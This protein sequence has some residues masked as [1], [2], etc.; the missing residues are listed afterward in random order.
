M[1]MVTITVESTRV[2]W[3]SY[4]EGALSMEAQHTP[5]TSTS[6]LT[7]HHAPHVSSPPSATMY[8]KRARTMSSASSGRDTGPLVSPTPAGST[9]AAPTTVYV[10]PTEKVISPVR[11][12]VPPPDSIEEVSV[13]FEFNSPLFLTP[14]QIGINHSCADKAPMKECVSITCNESSAKERKRPSKATPVKEKPPVPTVEDAADEVVTANAYGFFELSARGDKS[15]AEVTDEHLRKTVVSVNYNCRIEVHIKGEVEV[16]VESE[17]STV[18]RTPTHDESD[19][20]PS[21][22]GT[23]LRTDGEDNDKWSTSDNQSAGGRMM[24]PGRGRG[25]KRKRAGYNRH[26]NMIVDRK[27]VRT[28]TSGK[29]DYSYG[30]EEEEEATRD[31]FI[32]KKNKTYRVMEQEH[33]LDKFDLLDHAPF[34]DMSLSRDEAIGIL[35]KRLSELRELYRQNKADLLLMEERKRKRAEERRERERA[36]CEAMAVEK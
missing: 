2:H 35:D 8:S 10:S 18:P 20:E 4:N 33:L 1:V 22:S 34:V 9:T 5:A 11:R 17:G 6:H 27:Y 29:E 25:C 16:K 23:P 21:G 32:S 24:S 15:H 12:I 31:T 30:E 13:S 36:S 19:A 7:A 28:K 3:V 14:L 26:S